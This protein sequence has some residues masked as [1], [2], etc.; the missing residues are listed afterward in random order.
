MLN[1]NASLHFQKINSSYQEGWVHCD[2]ALLTGIVYLNEKSNPNGGTTIYKPKN[3][4]YNEK[5][6]DK[7]HSFYKGLLS[8]EDGIK[9]RNEHNEQFNESIIVKNEYN[10]LICFDGFL[11]HGAN[12]YTNINN[13]ERLTLV[14]FIHQLYIDDAKYPLTRMNYVGN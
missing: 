2:E 6:R 3:L 12:D 14:F 4:S 7:K 5:N 13:E 8:D 9:F 1:W 10:R 11:P